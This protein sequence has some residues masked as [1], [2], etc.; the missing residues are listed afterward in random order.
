MYLIDEKVN[1]VSIEL[2][3]E[4]FEEADVVGEH[5]FVGVVKLVDNDL[6]DV[7][8][9]EEVVD[10]GV[11][12]NVFKENAKGLQQLDFDVAPRPLPENLHVRGQKR[13]MRHMCAWGGQSP[14][15]TVPVE[16]SPRG[17]FRGKNR[18]KPIRAGRPK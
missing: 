10:A 11:V 17:S 4:S 2:E 5:F 16:R 12:A 3:R 1:S 6:V 15:C 13:H 18:K 7:V 14:L 9:R 8:L